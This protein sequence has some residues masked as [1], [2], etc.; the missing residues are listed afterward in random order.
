MSSLFQGTG[1]LS[2]YHLE[3]IDSDDDDTLLQNDED[4]HLSSS[5]GKS[6]PAPDDSSSL[7]EKP[8]PEKPAP[9]EEE[10]EKE[11]QR[12]ERKPSVSTPATKS[13]P[14]PSKEELLQMM[15]K[16]DRDIAAVE[17]QISTLQKKKVKDSFFYVC[18]VGVYSIKVCL[19]SYT[20]IENLVHVVI[21][22]KMYTEG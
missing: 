16:V 6:P 19:H 9:A 10:E 2:A 22:E 14:R 5:V 3:D 1:G 8:P 17:T 4:D 18:G 13:P 21:G 11:E 20:E 7:V 12:R 15:E